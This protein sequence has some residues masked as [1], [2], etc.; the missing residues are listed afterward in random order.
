MRITREISH[1]KFLVFLVCPISH[2]NLVRIS[3]ENL[4][5]NFCKGDQ[6]KESMKK[7]G[8]EVRLNGKQCSVSV[9]GTWQGRGH[10]FLIGVVTLI[11]IDTGKALDVAVMG[12]K[13]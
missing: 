7:A 13:L 6:A 11:S 12:K 10:A 2:E 5:R 8:E 4:T 9:D 3:R 1:E